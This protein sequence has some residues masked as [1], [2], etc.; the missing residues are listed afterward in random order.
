METKK[1]YKKPEFEEVKIEMVQSLCGS[2]GCDADCS[3]D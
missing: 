2:T 3:D 1:N